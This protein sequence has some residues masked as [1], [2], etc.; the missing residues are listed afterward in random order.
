VSSAR[1]T[2]SGLLSFEIIDPT[3]A[4]IGPTHQNMPFSDKKN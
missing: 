2:I 3:V 1:A 4:F